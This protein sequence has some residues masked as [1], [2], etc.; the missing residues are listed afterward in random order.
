MQFFPN[1]QAYYEKADELGIE[2]GALFYT[3]VHVVSDAERATRKATIKA[4]GDELS[5]TP[6]EKEEEK[7]KKKDKKKILEQE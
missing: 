7:K 4:Y 3:D 6:V 1:W 5:F 2:T